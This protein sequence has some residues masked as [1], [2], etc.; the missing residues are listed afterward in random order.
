MRAHAAIL[1]AWIEKTIQIYPEQARNSIS[2]GGERFRNPVGF[3]IRES[4]AKLLQELAGEMDAGRTS[5][6]LD[7]LVRLRA[8]QDCTPAEAVCFVFLLRQIIREQGA[9]DQFPDLERRIDEMALMTF[10]QYVKCREDLALVRINEAK[11]ALSVRQRT[12]DGL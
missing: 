1:D 12:R 3:T 10:D 7:G 2:R 11:R 4:L 6:A 5:E 9:R 8:V